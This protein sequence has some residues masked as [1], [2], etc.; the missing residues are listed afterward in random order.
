MGHCFGSYVSKD[1]LD[2]DVITNNTGVFAVHI[3]KD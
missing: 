1:R 3:N 2:S